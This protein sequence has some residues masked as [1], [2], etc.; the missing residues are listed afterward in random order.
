MNVSNCSSMFQ[1]KLGYGI[2]RKS[3]RLGSSFHQAADSLIAILKTP[4]TALVK[5][6]HT[7]SFPKPMF[8]LRVLLL[9]RSLYSSDNLSVGSLMPQH[10]QNLPFLHISQPEFQFFNQPF[11]NESL[12]HSP[13]HLSQE[14]VTQTS[15]V[16][17]VFP[18]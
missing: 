17:I 15:R 7:H 4:F 12:V 11:P 8:C 13:S 10:L 18:F 16:K 2:A 9:V 3:Q 1:M 14:Q 5:P 6:C